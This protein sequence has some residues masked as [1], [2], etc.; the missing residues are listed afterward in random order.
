MH[1]LNS[2]RLTMPQTISCL[3]DPDLTQRR[4]IEALRRRFNIS[5]ELAAA[6]A[7]LAHLGPRE[8]HNG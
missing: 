5:P 3:P 8:A 1:S 2:T 4:V 7:G 6:I